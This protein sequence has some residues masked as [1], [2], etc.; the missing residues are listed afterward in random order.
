MTKIQTKKLY[1]VVQTSN[2]TWNHQVGPTSDCVGSQ[3]SQQE[4]QTFIFELTNMICVVY[5][6]LVL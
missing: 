3:E 5:S 1:S 2:Q 4:R 6:L